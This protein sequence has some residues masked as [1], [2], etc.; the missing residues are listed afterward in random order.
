[1]AEPPA[2]RVVMATAAHTPIGMGGGWV[3]GAA[4]RG[5]RGPAGAGAGA[6]GVGRA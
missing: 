5:R 1:M 4:G 3:P 2:E 6:G